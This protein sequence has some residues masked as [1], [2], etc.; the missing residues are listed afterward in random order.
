M[1]NMSQVPITARMLPRKYTQ[2][3]STHRD[4]IIFTAKISHLILQECTVFGTRRNLVFTEIVQ[5][6]RLH[7][8]VLVQEILLG[9]TISSWNR[10]QFIRTVEQLPGVKHRLSY[11]TSHPALL[12]WP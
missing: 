9:E 5:T 12:R 4:Q 2:L 7:F 10:T 1:Q 6:L 11:F 8:Q 3:G